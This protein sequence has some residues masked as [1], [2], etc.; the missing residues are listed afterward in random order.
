MNKIFPYAKFFSGL[1]LLVASSLVVAQE[2]TL[3]QLD[4]DEDGKISI[5]EAVADPVLLASFGKIDTDGD[6]KISKEELAS[7][8]L[9]KERKD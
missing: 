6:G 3:E 5:K 4:T 7:L 9:I 8:D 2:H 1:F